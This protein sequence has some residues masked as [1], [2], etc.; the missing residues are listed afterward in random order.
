MAEHSL[1]EKAWEDLG[2]GPIS[3]RPAP[4]L[5][6]KVPPASRI[7]SP[8]FKGRSPPFSGIGPPSSRTALL[9]DKSPSSLINFGDKEGSILRDKIP[10]PR[11]GSQFQGYRSPS[12]ETGA[13]LLKDRIPQP[14]T[15][16]GFPYSQRTGFPPISEQAP[17]P[18]TDRSPS[19]SETGLRILR[20]SPSPQRQAYLH[21]R[22]SPHLRVRSPSSSSSSLPLPPGMELGEGVLGKFIED[23]WGH[24]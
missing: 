12:L 9:P 1:Q 5:R 15:G 8:H 18:E 19:S 16:T 6:D 20:D 2:P 7:S 14:Q 23:L 21:L 22:D 24:F 11:E 13:T 17:L 10:I 3:S 4:I